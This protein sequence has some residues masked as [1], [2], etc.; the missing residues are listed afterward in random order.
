MRDLVPVHVVFPWNPT[1]LP[2]HQ[3]R[4]LALS[5]IPKVGKDQSINNFL[6]SN[7]LQ[8]TLQKRKTKGEK[9]VSC[10]HLVALVSAFHTAS[11]SAA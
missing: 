4:L 6:A 9:K 5:T 3:L 11:Q 8:L 10:M 1:L 7:L 2:M